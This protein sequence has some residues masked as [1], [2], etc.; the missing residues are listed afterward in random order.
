MQREEYLEP[1]IMLAMETQ[2]HLPR[3]T[4]PPSKETSFEKRYFEGVRNDIADMAAVP[5][6]EKISA[7]V[8]MQFPAASEEDLQEAIAVADSLQ[9]LGLLL[10]SQYGESEAAVER[11]KQQVP[12]YSQKL[13]QNVISY[14]GYI[15]H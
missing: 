4:R 13:Y 8:M 12:G 10:E 7:E 9:Q 6:S 3:P 11:L 2:R 1:M 5:A 15:N 14:F